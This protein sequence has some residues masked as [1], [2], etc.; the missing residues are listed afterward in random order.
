MKY[1][2]LFKQGVAARRIYTYVFGG[3]TAASVLTML[4][5]Y[6]GG[7]KMVSWASGE[8]ILEV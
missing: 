8:M 7:T 6:T 5:P 2:L 1:L 3:C 4:A